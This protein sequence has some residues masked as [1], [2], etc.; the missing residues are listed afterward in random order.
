MLTLTQ[1]LPPGALIGA[2]DEALA[3][4]LPATGAV[5]FRA[6]AASAVVEGDKIT[7]WLDSTAT[8]RAVTTEPNTGASRHDASPPDAF[9]CETGTHCGFVVEKPLPDGRCFTAAVIYTSPRD[10][11]K[12]LLSVSTGQTNNLI[13]LSE[14]DGRLTAKDRDSTVEVSLPVIPGDG[15]PRLAIFAFNGRELRLSF[16]GSTVS[17]SGRVPAMDPPAQLFIGC[18]SNRAG[19]AKTLGNSRLHDVLIWPNRALLASS[20]PADVVALAC[21]HRYHLWAF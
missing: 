14:S 18:R 19:L 15:R 4:A 9:L 7:G 21:L 20:D 11:A 1:A 8:Q 13:F 6:D 10:E 17:S 5:W 16:N 3:Q 12:T 2:E